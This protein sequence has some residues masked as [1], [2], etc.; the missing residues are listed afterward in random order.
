MIKHVLPQPREAEVKELFKRLGFRNLLKRFAAFDR[1][2]SLDKAEET[3]DIPVLDTL[4]ANDIEDKYVA[5]AFTYERVA[6][7]L[8]AAAL[9]I[10][11]EAGVFAV[12][13]DEIGFWL[14]ALTR[15]KAVLTEDGKSLYKA[16]KY[17][18]CTDLPVFDV[19]LAAYLLEPTR[20]AYGL[21]YLSEA[22]G[23]PFHEDGSSEER[24]LG[25]CASFILSLRGPLSTALDAKGLTDLYT[26]VEAP[27][28]RTLAIM[29][30]NG[31]AV[32]KERLEEM[33]GE[34]SQEADGLE[35]KIY[36]LAGESFNINSTKQ[37]GVILF[38]K[39]ACPSLRRQRPDILRT[40][41]YWKNWPGR[42]KSLS[43]S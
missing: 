11:V 21:T 34:L 20:A 9:S 18:G 13:A 4:S 2:E 41:P 40:R 17:A 25:S 26:S 19:T 23:L 29:E 28:V 35:N 37:L 10:A 27:L 32:N 6:S 42:A 5:V 3:A 30:L 36:D 38:E 39:W 15:A 16:V 12:P 31:F 1:F 7:D 22:F 8:R 14:A 24:R 33:K 43:P